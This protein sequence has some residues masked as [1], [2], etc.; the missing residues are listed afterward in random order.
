MNKLIEFVHPELSL[1]LRSRIWLS[2][3]AFLAPVNTAVDQINEVCL[4]LISG[5]KI[6]CYSADTTTDKDDVN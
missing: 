5:D 3:R 1:N 6:E 4:D 2:E